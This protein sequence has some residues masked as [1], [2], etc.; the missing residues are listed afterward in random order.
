MFRRAGSP[1]V[2]SIVFAFIALTIVLTVAGVPTQDAAGS[3]P[4]TYPANPH[5][6]VCNNMKIGDVLSLRLLTLPQTAVWMLASGNNGPS[7]IGPYFVDLGPDWFI[8]LGG[9]PMGGWV[10]LDVP[11]PIPDVPA[12]VGLEF[13]VQCA[14][15]PPLS[16]NPGF[17]NA[18]TLRC[19]Q[20]SGKNIL[21]LRQTAVM[22]GMTNAAQQATSLGSSLTLFG[23]Q[24]TIVDDVLP[25][26]SALL[27][28]D[29]LL[30]LRFSVP[31]AADETW[32]LVEFLRQC[33]G[34][35]FVSGPYAG[36]PS[37]Q[38]RATWLSGFLATVGADVAIS[39]GGTHSNASTEPV[40]FADP[41]FL[42]IPFG[43]A[44]LTFDVSYEGGN[45]GPPGAASLGAPWL[46]GS[47][48][49]GDLT[50]GMFFQ[51]SE[52]M[53]QTVGG[54]IGVLFAGGPD[55]FQPSP[56]NAYPDLIMCNVAWYLDR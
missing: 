6:L 51:P 38:Q 37:G 26:S 20:G 49:A 50:F 55:T 1:L 44:G 40:E 29:C 15:L 27:D 14:I 22:P 41:A 16:T 36:C 48:P 5:R 7:Y 3:A 45:F 34:V 32:R 21:I 53:T 35:F 9:V 8:L 31:P 12:L 10:S 23:N 17:S 19:S 46:A 2:L 33:G 13:V 56:Q 24:V 42:T 18:V 25:S 4:S 11:I 39:S 47:T 54:R 43:I 30:D 28:F 52:T